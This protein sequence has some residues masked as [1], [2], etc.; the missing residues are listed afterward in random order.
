MLKY[1][2]NYRGWH[3]SA[4][5]VPLACQGNDCL[6]FSGRAIAV[7]VEPIESHLWGG[8]GPQVTTLVARRFPSAEACLAALLDLARKQIDDCK[9]PE[10]LW[11]TWC[12]ASA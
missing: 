12:S 7:L 5:C 6:C 10:T 1:S 3:I 2:M 9:K 8:S 4:A 11:E